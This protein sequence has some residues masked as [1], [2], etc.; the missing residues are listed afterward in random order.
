MKVNGRLDKYK[1]RLVVTGTHSKQVEQ[2]IGIRLDTN[3]EEV[4]W[5][6]L[7]WSQEV[8][9]KH[10]FIG[11]LTVRDRLSTKARLMQWGI[12]GDPSCL[13]CRNSI[14]DMVTSSLLAPLQKESRGKL[15]SCVW[16]QISQPVGMIY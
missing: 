14:E 8:I 16:F 5:G 4:Q 12:G 10:G 6:K 15:W 9:H 13:F 1:A 7:V 2:Q 3:A 11:C